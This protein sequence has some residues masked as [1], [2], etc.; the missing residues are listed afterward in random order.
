MNSRIEI[1]WLGGAPLLCARL[2]SLQ[3]VDKYTCAHSHTHHTSTN[4]ILLQSHKKADEDRHAY[5]SL[6]ESS[7]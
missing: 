2:D 1:Y 5:S 6:G 3:G 4:H 7:L